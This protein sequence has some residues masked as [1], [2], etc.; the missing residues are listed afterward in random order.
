MALRL[1]MDQDSLNDAVVNALRTAGI[2]VVTAE[3]V[4]RQ[5]APD[6]EQLTFATASGRVIY[7]ANRGDFARIHTEW[8]VQGRSHAGIITRS[9]QAMRVGEQIRGLRRICAAFEPGGAVNLF[10]Y[11]EA[12]VPPTDLTAR[13]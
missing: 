10:E 11:L 4:G 8:M 3:D 2:D 6:D 12:W 5:R 7:T 1:Y 13:R 9:H